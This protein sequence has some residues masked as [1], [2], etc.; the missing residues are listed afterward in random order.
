[1]DFEFEVMDRLGIGTLSDISIPL[2]FVT[3][4]YLNRYKVIMYVYVWF[5]LGVLGT[6]AFFSGCHSIK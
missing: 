4:C 6:G 3:F 1:M 5:N 2:E